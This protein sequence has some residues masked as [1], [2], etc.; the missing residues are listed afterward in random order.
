[1]L[2]Y[3][4]VSDSH[5]D[6]VLERNHKWFNE[7]KEYTCYVVSRFIDADSYDKFKNEDVPLKD[8]GVCNGITTLMDEHLQKFNPNI[9]I[10]SKDNLTNFLRDVALDAIRGNVDLVDIRSIIPKDVIGS[11]APNIS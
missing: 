8:L 10:L 7:L 2:K 9:C 1:M 3:D 6:T 11:V 5:I 4:Y